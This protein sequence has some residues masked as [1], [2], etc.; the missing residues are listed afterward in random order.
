MKDDIRF[1]RETIM[2]SGGRKLYSYTFDDP[3]EA[4]DPGDAREETRRD[5]DSNEELKTE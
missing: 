2:I 3:I 1:Q 5:G 4:M